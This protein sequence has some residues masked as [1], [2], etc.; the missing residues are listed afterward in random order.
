MNGAIYSMA[1]GSRFRPV[2]LMVVLI[3]SLA[4][5]ACGVDDEDDPTPVPA[6]TAVLAETPASVATAPPEASAVA[7]S[8][9]T[10]APAAEGTPNPLANTV[11]RLAEGIAA[12]W[13]ETSYR[14]VQVS[15]AVEGETAT[16]SA[17]VASLTITD[18][19]LYPGSVHRTIVDGNGAT[20]A[21]FILVDERLFA[22][23]ELVPS[24]FATGT[25]PD[26]WIELSGP[27][28]TPGTAGSNILTQLR[29]LLS[30]RY[31]DISAE[32]Q[33]RE[34]LLTAE[35][36]VD[37]RACFVFQ[38]A[39]TTQ[40]GERL[41]VGIALEATGRL[42]SVTTTG[43]GLDTIET[44]TFDAPVTIAI[45]AETVAFSG[46]GTPPAGTPASTPAATPA[47]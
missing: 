31:S 19:V 28:L 23:G 47:A 46:A 14:R 29:A 20:S 35:T 45:P 15:T 4:L 43:G 42:C 37:G 34:A 16:V 41:E 13:P 10:A 25:V 38:T 11:G 12:V 33:A 2:S 21:E 40:T 17:G 36:D 18:E 44:F 7:A 39:E 27:L 22:R 8:N 26:A 24:L 9:T 3:A 5:A 1:A 30:P 6:T 32:Q